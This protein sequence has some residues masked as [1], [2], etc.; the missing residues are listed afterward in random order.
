MFKSAKNILF[1]IF[2]LVKI[3]STPV[4]LAYPLPIAS[5][6]AYTLSNFDINSFIVSYIFCLLFITAINLWN[7]LNDVEDDIRAGRQFSVT[8][9]K[10]H[11]SATLF[12]IFLY[13]SS[14]IIVIYF[15]KSIIAIPAFAISSLITWMYSD[16]KFFGKLVTRFKEWYVS[17]LLTYIVVSPAFLIVV[18]SFFSD[19]SI[20][21]VSYTIIFSIFCISGALLKD[22]KDISSDMRAGYKT[23]G[24]MFDAEFLLKISLILNV[25]GITVILI[26]SIFSIIP[27]Y[28]LISGIVLIL[29]IYII[30]KLAS[31]NWSVSPQ[32]IGVLKLHPISYLLALV[33]LAVG[34]IISNLQIP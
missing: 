9:Q 20:K 13:F 3:G 33:L 11:K 18:W 17:E 16:K 15:T 19:I 6:V 26:S 1:L 7:H 8:L 2:H 12:V 29:L 22:L 23:L 10:H 25:I 27:L 4:T 21:G 5:I 30:W 24:V 32:N 14:A 28:C 34:A 31:S